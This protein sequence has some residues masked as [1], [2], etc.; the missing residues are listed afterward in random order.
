MKKIFAVGFLAVLAIALMPERVME[1]AQVLLMGGLVLPLMQVKSDPPPAPLGEGDNKEQNIDVEKLGSV[2][3]SNLDEAINTGKG[4]VDPSI[5]GGGAAPG[6]SKEEKPGDD[7]PKPGEETPEPGAAGGA[8]KKGDKPAG[9]KPGDVKDDTTEG[10]KLLAG[11]FKTEPDLKKGI[12]EA[13]KALKYSEKMVEKAIA[14][15]KSVAELEEMYKEMDAAISANRKA[16]DT[17]RTEPG[18]PGAVAAEAQQKE[19]QEVARYIVTETLNTIKRNPLIRMLSKNGIE[20]PDKFLSDKDVTEEFMGRLYDLEPADYYELKRL[21]ESTFHGVKNNVQQYV[22][23]LRES[24]ASNTS[25]LA[26]EE[27]EIAEYAK[28]IG[29]PWTPEQQKAFVDEAVKLPTVYE[30]R[31]GVDFLKKVRNA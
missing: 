28:G 25:T 15:A 11:R 23:T 4:V 16:A 30:A 19:Q 27:K 20:L 6:A 13:A 14:G 1:I 31:N 26:A 24:E 12:T 3:D 17:A 29:L 10:D 22:T 18:K 2:G 21:T 9:E 5:A 7:K 8:L